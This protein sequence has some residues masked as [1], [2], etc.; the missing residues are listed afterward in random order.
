[1]RRVPLRRI[2]ETQIDWEAREPRAARSCCDQ[3]RRNDGQLRLHR[4]G[5]RRQGQHLHAR[6]CSST[7]RHAPA[8]GDVGAAHLHRDRLA[9]TSRRGST[10]A[11]TTSCFTP[12]GRVAPPA[13]AAGRRESASIRSSRSSS[14][15]RT[16]RP[17]WRRAHGIP[18]IFYG[19]NEAEYGNHIEDNVEPDDGPDVLQRPTRPRRRSTRRRFGRRAASTSH[20]VAPRDLEPYLPADPTQLREA[21]SRS[22]TSA[23]T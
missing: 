1:M 3:Y 17:R 18:L 4:P 7:V 11:S 23:T 8:D 14:A 6:T 15:R 21:G 2:K 13:D 20:G 19:E 22:T 12:N 5:Q 9:R 16:S 10:R